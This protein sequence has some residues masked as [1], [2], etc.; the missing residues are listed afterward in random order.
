MTL[1]VVGLVLFIA[2]H[3]LP[4]A[5]R[6]R[7][8]LVARLGRNPYKGVFSIVS[9][10]GLVLVVWG[11]SAAPFEPVYTPPSWGRH[12]AMLAVPIALV[13]FAAANMPTHIRA[14][15]K[16][17]MMLGLALWAFAHLLANGD[18]RSIVLF[19]SFAA[20]AVVATLGAVV[21]GKTLIGEKPPRWAMDAAAVVAGVVVAGLLMRFHASLS[22]MPVLH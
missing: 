22:G 6:L 3:L 4:S 5:Q 17:P 9:L 21:R 11:F 18:L 16:H 20:F 10:A 15:L 2:V 12:A 1:L 19:G 14:G 13:L 8:P 7:A